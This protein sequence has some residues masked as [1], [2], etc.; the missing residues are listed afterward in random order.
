IV[1]SAELEHA[2]EIG[3]RH[4]ERFVPPT[5]GDE[6]AIVR[7]GISGVDRHELL[8]RVDGRDPHAQPELDA[9]LRVEA[10]AVDELVLEAVHAAEIALRQG[11]AIVRQ[12]ALGADEH[13]VSVPTLFAEHRRRA[14]APQGRADDHDSLHA[15][16]IAR[17]RM[18]S[19]ATYFPTLVALT[20]VMPGVSCKHPSMRLLHLLPPLAWTAL[21]AWLSTDSWSAAKTAPA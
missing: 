5:G 16:P 14:R 13:D 15:P 6:Q 1:D 11:R 12:L 18:L 10:R 8:R 17:T 4:R 19:S 3:A 2:I 7:D 9:S 20:V 21:I